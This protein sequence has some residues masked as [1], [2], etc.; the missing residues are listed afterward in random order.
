MSHFKNSPQAVYPEALVLEPH[1][2]NLLELLQSTSSDSSA[3]QSVA[4]ASPPISFGL[5]FG[6]EFDFAIPVLLRVVYNT[7][8]PASHEGLQLRVAVNASRA[9]QEALQ[10]IVGS[11]LSENSSGEAILLVAAALLEDGPSIVNQH[12]QQQ[13]TSTGERVEGLITQTQFV[14]AR[15][16][17]WR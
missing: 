8:Y 6:V 4:E 7:H 9:V 2:A 15:L 5:R 17:I 10:R 3:L 11:V 12:V 16:L 14:L 1:E 13:K